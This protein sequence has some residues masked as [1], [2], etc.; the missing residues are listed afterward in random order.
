[1]GVSYKVAG[2][3]GSLMPS[4]LYQECR[5]GLKAYPRDTEAVAAP[6]SAHT[7]SSRPLL[8]G[9]FGRQTLLP[10]CSLNFKFE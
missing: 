1:M 8:S 10:T 4:S 3:H 7:A 5:P 2:E 6:K 9:P